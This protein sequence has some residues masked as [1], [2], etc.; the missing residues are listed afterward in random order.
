MVIP[1]APVIA[2]MVDF[3]LEL[4]SNVELQAANVTFVSGGLGFVINRFPPLLCYGY[5]GGVIFY[6]NI[7]P[8]I[9]IFIV[10][11]TELILLFTIV[12]RVS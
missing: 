2:V 7:L 9:L 5:N 4:Q 8:L 3:A 1:L 12:H 11:I 10:G 6:G